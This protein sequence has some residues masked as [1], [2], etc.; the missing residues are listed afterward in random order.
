MYFTSLTDHQ[1]SVV[2]VGHSRNCKGVS[3]WCLQHR[4]WRNAYP[5]KRKLLFE[6]EK[7]ES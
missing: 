2:V 7:K 6:I 1:R 5:G 4:K 3:R